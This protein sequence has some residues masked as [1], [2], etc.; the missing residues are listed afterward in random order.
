MASPQVKVPTYLEVLLLCA[1]REL[2]QMFLRAVCPSAAELEGEVDVEDRRL[3]LRVLAGDPSETPGWEDTVLR[4]HAFAL[5][6]RYLDLL[7]VE[8][9]RAIYRRLP[10]G[11]NIPLAA[12]LVRE[13]GELDF[14]I[15]CLNC[16]QKL[17]VRDS[18]SGRQGRCPNCQ[19]IFRLPSQAGYLRAQL[20]LPDQVP[21]LMVVVGRP[22]A[23]RGA[24]A[25]L[26]A[27]LAPTLAG[28]AMVGEDILKK[29]TVPVIL[30]ESNETSHD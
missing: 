3:H 2:G 13:E 12:F 22:A 21:T 7:S 19:K 28:S 23:C 16:A 15:S 9:L 30:P 10:I 8:R 20:A 27:P 18:D 26:I 4:A 17:W 11:S 14:K 25:R 1:E 24:L 6:A 29:S 5:L